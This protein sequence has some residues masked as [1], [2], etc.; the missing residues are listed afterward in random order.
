MLAALVLALAAA[1]ASAETA[2]SDYYASLSGIEVDDRSARKGC[3]TV[4]LSAREV[5]L[6]NAATTRS[7]SRARAGAQLKSADA[8][9]ASGREIMAAYQESVAD[10]QRTGHAAATHKCDA[11]SREGRV[12]C[13]AT[14]KALY[15]R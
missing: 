13:N 7:A 15:R 11:L 14:T 5:C 1:D 8:G 12:S 4:P 6:D 3:R 2:R 10:A 9:R